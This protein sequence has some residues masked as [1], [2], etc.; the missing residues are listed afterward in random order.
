MIDDTTKEMVYR[1]YVDI[2]VA[3]A[4]PRV[5]IMETISPG[6][7]IILIYEKGLL[8]LEISQV[9]FYDIE[10]EPID[11]VLLCSNR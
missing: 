4:T 1:E 2:S 7:L 6:Q 11:V 8:G 3:V 5:G 9:W 10:A